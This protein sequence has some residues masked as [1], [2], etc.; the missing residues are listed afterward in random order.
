QRNVHTSTIDS[1]V[2]TG[3]HPGFVAPELDPELGVAHCMTP[4]ALRE[5]LEAAPGAVGVWAVSPTYFGATADVEALAAIAHERGVPL[6]V[7]EAWGGHPPF[8]DPL[9]PATLRQGAALVISSTHKM[10]GSLTGS[11]ILHLADTELLD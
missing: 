2:L 11:A 7:D 9:P 4:E 8:S 6:I 1:L 5:E 10:V 3:L